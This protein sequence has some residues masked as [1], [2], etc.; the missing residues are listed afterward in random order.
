M[1]IATAALCL[2]AVL[3]FQAR[4]SPDSAANLAGWSEIAAQ[5]SDFDQGL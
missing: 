5:A 2:F 3:L 1:A 4:T